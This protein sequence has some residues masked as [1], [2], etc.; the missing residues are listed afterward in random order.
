MIIALIWRSL[1]AQP[2]LWR[3]L[4]AT[5]RCPKCAWNPPNGLIT[6]PSHK[7]IFEVVFVRRHM[8]WAHF[9]QTLASR[10]HPVNLVQHILRE[11]SPLSLSLETLTPHEKQEDDRK[12]KRHPDITE[13]TGKDLLCQGSAFLIKG[14]L[15]LLYRPW[16]HVF[17]TSLQWF[18]MNPK[19]S[20]WS[21]FPSL[22]FLLLKASKKEGECS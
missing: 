1:F 17:Q 16:L 20:R 13:L 18:L 10:R 12:C 8:F 19:Y 6:Y 9:A 11:A 5:Q 21:F 7:N 22:P 15:T 14:L 3:C 4:F 2:N